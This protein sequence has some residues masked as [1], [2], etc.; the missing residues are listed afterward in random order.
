ML[1]SEYMPRVLACKVT[2]DQGV[3]DF[4]VVL[5]REMFAKVI[6]EEKLAVVLNRNEFRT[7]ALDR[8]CFFV[9]NQLEHVNFRM[10]PSEACFL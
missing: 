9:V 10:G 4:C 2:Y 3:S 5:R 7:L 1:F 8:C 6:E